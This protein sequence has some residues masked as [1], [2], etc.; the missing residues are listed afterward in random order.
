MK[1]IGREHE[2]SILHDA[3]SSDRPEFIAIYGRRRIG[4]TFLVKRFFEQANCAFLSITGLHNGKLKEQIHAFTLEL[5]RHFYDGAPLIDANNWQNAFEQLHLAIKRHH[6]QN[7]KMV[8]FLDE[9]PWMAGRRSNLL[10]AI[11]Y[12]W[13]QHWSNNP[14]IKLIICGSSASWMIKKIINDRGGLHN[15]LTKRV[16]LGPLNLKETETFL[17]AHAIKL[18]RKQLAELYMVTGGIP[19]YLSMSKKGLSATQQI[20]H[21]AFA[22][23]A[24]LLKEFDNLFASLFDDADAHIELLRIIASERSGMGAEEIIAASKS[25]TRGGRLQSKLS[26][27]ED[28]GFI[29]SFQSHFA[30]HRG[31]YY[32]LIDE[33]TLFYLQWIEPIRN[34]LN[35]QSMPDQYWASIQ[36]MPAWN[37]WTGYAFEALCYKHLPQI[38]ASLNIPPTAIANTWRYIPRNKANNSGAQIDLLFDRIDDTIS[39]CE[40]KYT[41]KPFVIDKAYAGELQNKIDV[42]K[43]RTRT[44]KL[45]LLHLISSAG[46]KDN[47]YSDALIASALAL[48]DLF[49]K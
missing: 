4:K 49:A 15:R 30:K 36:G 42:F 19:Y 10:A 24:P 22:Q 1:L 17:A 12:Y 23:N 3:L 21:L 48:D 20:D 32:R 37:T 31:Y 47:P 7:K 16:Q 5:S 11:D 46:F 45:C 2:Q 38:R 44:K 9:L 14:N 41:Q 28:A 8:I 33:Y 40:I 26:A 43:Q 29:I 39:I 35:K 18:P 27:L 34:T 6:T 25:L 13:N